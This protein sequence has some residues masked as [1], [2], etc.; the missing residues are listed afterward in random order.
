MK[1]MREKLVCLVA[2]TLWMAASAVSAQAQTAAAPENLVEKL[3]GGTD[4]APDID[5]PALRQQIAERIK[6]KADNT[7]LRR[8]PI[9]PQLLKLPQSTFEI[10]F[11]PDTPIVR[12]ASYRTIGRIADAL[13]NPKLQPDMFLVVAH[14][15]STG[16]RE[17]NVTLSQRR[18]DAVRDILSSTFKVSPKRLRSVGL[19]EEQ[20][21]DALRPTAPANLRV[22]IIAIGEMPAAAPPP[23]TAPAS[24]GKDANPKAKNKKK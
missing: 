17:I 12:P 15:E 24:K 2:A 10:Q 21:Q 14:T 3:S 11:D 4:T 13:T 8:P 19:G 6:T 9:A 7:A 1:P 5:I 23:T 22:Q 16:R 20:L 18:A